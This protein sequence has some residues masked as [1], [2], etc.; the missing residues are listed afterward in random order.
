MPQPT[1]NIVVVGGGTGGT[2][3]ANLLAKQLRDEIH[4]GKIRVYLISGADTHIFQ[5][6][7][8]H[9]AFK[10]QDPN[11]IKHN[12]QTL[13]RNE[14]Q[15]I[16]QDAE[17]IDLINRRVSVVSGDVARI[18]LSYNRNGERAE[19]FRDSG[20]WG[21]ILELPHKRRRVTKDMDHHRAIQ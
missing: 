5:P 18:R 16:P 14:V 15:R 1:T 4:G 11:E 2:L 21:G 10:N 9:V 12:E 19:P 7:Y 13:V 17:K 6:G 3:A 20:T 8:L